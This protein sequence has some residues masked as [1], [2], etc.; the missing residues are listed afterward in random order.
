M[1]MIATIGSQL[2]RDGIFF[3][4]LDAVDSTIMEINFFSP[5]GLESAAS[6]AV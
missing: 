1:K 3:V 4:G 2:L 5:G 6:F